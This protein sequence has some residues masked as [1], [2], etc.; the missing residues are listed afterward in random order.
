MRLFNCAVILL[1]C[2]NL[3]STTSPLAAQ[4]L[5]SLERPYQGE[6]TYEAMKKVWPWMG[7]QWTT[8]SP[9][10]SRAKFLSDW[11]GALRTYVYPWGNNSGD[12]T[13]SRA[14][15]SDYQL[16]ATN[17]PTTTLCRKFGFIEEGR[18]PGEVKLGPGAY[19]DDILMCRFVD[20]SG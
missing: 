7:G 9:L 18:R 17:K 1:A 14:A 13:A 8:L 16:L 3:G 15:G 19:V 6:A 2:L 11:N 10:H 20:L 4:Q 12:G 5:V